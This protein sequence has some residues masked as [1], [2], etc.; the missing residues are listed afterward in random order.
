M[1]WRGYQKS[2]HKYGAVAT[3]VDGIKFPSKMEAH[4]YQQLRLLV[5]AKIIDSLSTQVRF[6]LD[7]LGTKVCSYIADFGYREAATGLFVYE[8]VKGARTPVFNLKMKLFKILYPDVNLRII[9]RNGNEAK[10]K[11]RRTKARLG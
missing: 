5:E 11:D 10:K 8:D 2:N 3:V 4:R 1:G 9:D 7:V 6:D